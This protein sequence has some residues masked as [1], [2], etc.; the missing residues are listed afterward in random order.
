M[1]IQPVTNL[2]ILKYVGDDKKAEWAK[3]FMSEGFKG[4]KKVTS[5]PE[6]SISEYS[7]LKVSTT[8]TFLRSLDPVGLARKRSTHLLALMHL[9]TRTVAKSITHSQ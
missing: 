5:H 9:P 2:R 7:T 8:V 3:H 1:D 6:K 4:E